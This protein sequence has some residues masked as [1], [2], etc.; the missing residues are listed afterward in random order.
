VI[1]GAGMVR[2][3]NILAVDTVTVTVATCVTLTAGKV[4]KFVMV[5]V[6]HTQ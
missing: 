3:E 4:A 2:S 5:V 6:W 1:T